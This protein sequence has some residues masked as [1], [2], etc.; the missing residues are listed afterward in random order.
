M[1]TAQEVTAAGLEWVRL[2]DEYT[3]KS[4]AWENAHPDERHLGW[5]S[6]SFQIEVDPF[7]AVVNGQEAIWKGLM[8]KHAAGLMAEAEATIL[9]VADEVVAEP[10]SAVGDGSL[11]GEVKAL[12][13]CSTVPAHE[14]PIA[15]SE[16]EF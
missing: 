16:A 2:L 15:T 13:G 14:D 10:R 3:A 7:I 1:T 5:Q 8:R 4:R 11:I 12:A 9:R 6:A